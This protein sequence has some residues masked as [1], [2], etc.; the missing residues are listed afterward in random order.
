MAAATT[1]FRLQRQHPV[2]DHAF[3]HQG[4]DQ[5]LYVGQRGQALVVQLL[6]GLQVFGDL[7]H[8]GVLAGLAWAVDVLDE[9]DPATESGG[10][11]G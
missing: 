10:T 9:V 11:R 5:P 4:R 2:V 6:K 3:H 8:H 1:G 7:A